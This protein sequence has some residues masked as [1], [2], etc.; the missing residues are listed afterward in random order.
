MVET[1]IRSK[2]RCLLYAASTAVSLVW[3]WALAA[4]AWS[5]VWGLPL[6]LLSAAGLAAWAA[7]ALLVRSGGG[8]Q[9]EVLAAGR[10]FAARP[11]LC[12][13]APLL[14]AVAAAALAVDLAYAVYDYRTYAFIAQ[15]HA[16]GG[17]PPVAL[18][19]LGGGHYILVFWTTPRVYL[20]VAALL[21][22]AAASAPLLGR[23]LWYYRA[24][25]RAAE[26]YEK[27]RELLT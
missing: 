22:A 9:L 7:P 3:V 25:W 20:A 23:Y 12:L 6:V 26:I 10:L 16:P 14:H 5:G 2:S 1:L 21:T 4:V 27:A 24:L 11:W 19:D 13:S 18:V 15:V 17:L 8:D